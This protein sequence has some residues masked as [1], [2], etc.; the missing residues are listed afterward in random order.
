LRQRSCK[1]KWTFQQRKLENIKVIKE[2][3]ESE[4]KK[5]YDLEETVKC[6]VC[7]EVPRKGPVFACPNGHLVCQKCKRASCATCRE[8]MG[9]HK[10]LLAVAVIEKI[11]HE[12]KFVECKQKWPL[13]YIDEHEKL[14]KHRVVACPD[15]D[16]VQRV[17]LS[18]LLAHLETSLDCSYDRTPLDVDGS[19]IAVH[20]NLQFAMLEIP[21]IDWKVRTFCFEGHFYSLNVNKSGDTWQFVIVMFESILVCSENHVEIEVYEKDSYPDTRLSAKVRCNP[22]SID[23]TEAELEGF[24]LIVHHKFMKMM[25]KEDNFFKFTVCLSFF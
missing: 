22:C 18:K 5:V 16:C 2:E 21:M 10:S 25:L 13:D 17:P 4:K 15:I 19:T 12:C 8:V 23:H 9:D 1:I 14:C 7:L 20:L 6:P 11:L 3:L 24:G